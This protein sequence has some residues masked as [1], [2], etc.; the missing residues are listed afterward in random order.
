MKGT[1]VLIPLGAASGE[2]SALPDWASDCVGIPGQKTP[3]STACWAR[4]AKEGYHQ[5]VQY[6]PASRYWPLQWIVTAILFGIS[7]LAVSFSFWW[8]RKRLT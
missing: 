7:A 2:V 4:L 6:L 5:R 3:K 1:K 8:L